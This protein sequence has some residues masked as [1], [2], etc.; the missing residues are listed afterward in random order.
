[1]PKLRGVETKGQ[2]ESSLGE[3]RSVIAR[4]AVELTKDFDN[5]CGL[6]TELFQWHSAEFMT[7]DDE[8][9]EN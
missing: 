7:G 9:D 6:N 4:D 3:I 2:N 8:D 1:M 5:A